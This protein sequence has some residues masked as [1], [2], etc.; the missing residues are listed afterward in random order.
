MTQPTASGS[1]RPRPGAPLWHGRP[2]RR[3]RARRMPRSRRATAALTQPGAG[4]DASSRRT[5]AANSLGPSGHADRSWLRASRNDPPPQRQSP[6]ARARNGRPGEAG[7][8]ASGRSDLDAFRALRALG[9]LAVADRRLGVVTDR[10]VGLHVVERGI[11]RIEHPMQFVVGVACPTCPERDHRADV[12]DV[13]EDGAATQR[14]NNL[15]RLQRGMLRP[16][17]LASVGPRPVAW[18]DA[19]PGHPASAG[20]SQLARP[21]SLVRGW[22][23]RAARHRAARR[24]APVVPAPAPGARAGLHV[25]GRRSRTRRS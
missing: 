18:D 6:T 13:R 7:G 15:R 12:L 3:S 1:S 25:A 10:P 4:G 17:L 9:S 8:S 2:R 19:C 14:Q 5:P 16:P 22:D 21:M 20:R 23:R 24:S 11:A